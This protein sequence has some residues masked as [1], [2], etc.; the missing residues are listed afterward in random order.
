MYYLLMYWSHFLNW[1]VSLNFGCRLK[2]QDL[3]QIVFFFFH[4][5]LEYQEGIFSYLTQSCNELA[6]LRCKCCLVPQLNGDCPM[7]RP[8]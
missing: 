8:P 2:I 4:L 3:V 5:L 7:H 6:F 1:R